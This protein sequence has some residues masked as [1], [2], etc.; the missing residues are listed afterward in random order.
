MNRLIKM[1]YL[2]RQHNCIII[3]YLIRNQSF[4]LDMNFE[5]IQFIISF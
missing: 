2:I 5:T 1:D 4:D 3:I